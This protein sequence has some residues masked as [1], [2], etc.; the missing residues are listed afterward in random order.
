VKVEIA[1]AKGKKKG[2]KRQ[3]IQSREADREMARAKKFSLKNYL[4]RAP[5]GHS[6]MSYTT[7]TGCVRVQHAIIQIHTLSGLEHRLTLEP[8]A[9]RISAP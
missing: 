6:A 4:V 9:L 7:V 5:R 3:S 2:D 1:L 8:I